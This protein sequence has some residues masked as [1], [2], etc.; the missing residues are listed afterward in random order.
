M[1]SSGVSRLVIS[2]IF[3]HV[4]RGV[5]AV[6]DRHSYDVKKRIALDAW[7]RTL[8]A[9]IEQKSADVLSFARS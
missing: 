3:N 1:A 2:K 5:T 9:I 7:A 4:E 8:T 6:Y